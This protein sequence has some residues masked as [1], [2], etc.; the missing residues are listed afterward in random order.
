MQIF[1]T[2]ATGFLGKYL[3]AQLAPHFDHIY[4]L[5]RNLAKN[6]FLKFENVSLIKGDITRQIFF[7]KMRIRPC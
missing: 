1:I 7:Q 2:G 4:I 6:D 5:T 3:V